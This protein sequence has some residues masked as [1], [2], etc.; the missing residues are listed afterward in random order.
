MK[1]RSVIF[2]VMFLLFISYNKINSV[3]CKGGVIDNI[4]YEFYESIVNIN[5]LKYDYEMLMN[6]IDTLSKKYPEQLEDEVIGESYLG[7]KIKCIVLGNR[8]AENKLLIIGNAHARETHTTPLIVKQ[9]EYYCENWENEYNGEKVKDIFNNSAIFFVPT[10]NPD[11]LELVMNGFGSV[12]DNKIIELKDNIILA[13]ERKVKKYFVEDAD[14][15]KKI[16]INNYKFREEDLIM[17]KSNINGVDLHYNFYEEG[18]NEEEVLKWKNNEASRLVDETFSSENYIGPYGCSESE[19]KAIVNLINKYD[20]TQY[21]IS[22]HG[23]G[24]TIYWNYNTDKQNVEK[25]EK[26]VRDISEISKSPYSTKNSLPVGFAGWYQKKYNGFSAVIEVGWSKF[27][28]VDNEQSEVDAC[29]LRDEQFKYIWEAQK[30]VPIMIVQK[31][32]NK[33]KII[34]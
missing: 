24:P 11:G 31:Y 26:I 12:P 16:D 32:V 7:R 6:D 21:S 28:G 19:T 30:D 23:R 13:L 17:W 29:P 15:D 14:S 1:K 5:S 10:Q 18:V 27:Q 25:Y 34:Q 22:Y 2:L 8:D 9:I 4:N 20:L 33:R 3:I